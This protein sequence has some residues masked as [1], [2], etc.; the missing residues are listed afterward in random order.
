MHDHLHHVE[1]IR[2]FCVSLTSSHGGASE[3]APH[4]SCYHRLPAYRYVTG[5]LG[6]LYWASAFSSL[7]RIYIAYCILTVMT[8][9]FLIHLFNL[10]KKLSRRRRWHY[11]EFSVLFERWVTGGFSPF[12]ARSL[13]FLFHPYFKRVASHQIA[14]TPT[15]TGCADDSNLTAIHPPTQTPIPKSNR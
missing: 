8:H 12:S 3:F 6:L 14:D 15:Q 1:P 4:D 10:E 13:L 5:Y 7:A 11:A 9:R 2:R